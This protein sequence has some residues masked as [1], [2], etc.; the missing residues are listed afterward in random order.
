MAHLISEAKL[1]E[2]FRL[3]VPTYLIGTTY[4][5]S[6]AF[7]ESVVLP[8]VDQTRLHGCVILCDR[9]GFARAVEE[10]AALREATRTYSFTLVPHSA[11]FHPK[12]WVMVNAD[13]LAILVGSGNLTQS[14]FSE[15]FELFEVMRVRRDSAVLTLAA[16]IRRY[17][18]DLFDL[19]PSHGDYQIP[20]R[21]ILRDAAVAVGAL[22]LPQHTGSTADEAHFQ[23]SFQGPFPTQWSHRL[24]P[25]A[26]LWIASPFFGGSTAGIKLLRSVLQPQSTYVFPALHA[27]G[28]I[29]LPWDNLGDIEQTQFLEMPLHRR[30]PAFAHFKLYGFETI[31]GE[32]WVF[33]GSVNC[34]VAALSGHNVEAG[35][36][37]KVS[38]EVFERY[39]SLGKA[40]KPR[41][42]LKQEYEQLRVG[43]MN[44]WAM[45]QGLGFDLLIELQTP[46]RLPLRNVSLRLE[47]GSEWRT[48]VRSCMFAD[49]IREQVAWKDFRVAPG[50]AAVCRTVWVQATDAAGQLVAGVAFVDDAASLTSEPRQRN[51]WRGA[52]TL[53]AQ[54]G[55]PDAAELTAVFALLDQMLI[56]GVER[57]QQT[58]VSPATPGEARTPQGAAN[59]VAI[60]PPISAPGHGNASMHFGSD[61]GWFQKILGGLLRQSTASPAAPAL[62]A[63][64]AADEEQATAES[65]AL[66]KAA[67]ARW[68]HTEMQW[69]HLKN[70]FWSAV[71][72]KEAAP[73]VLPVCVAYFL[74][75]LCV[76]RSA[77][78]A[79]PQRDLPSARDLT[80]RFLSLMLGYRRQHDNYVRPRGCA[81]G[82]NIFPPL[83]VDLA[84]RLEDLPDASLLTVVLAFFVHLRFQA[85][86]G[87]TEGFPMLLWLELIAVIPS[88]ASIPNE[89]RRR[90]VATVMQRFLR[91]DEPMEPSQIDAA[92]DEVLAV[93]WSQ[94]PGY[95]R[96]EQIAVESAEENSKP[97]RVTSVDPCTRVCPRCHIQQAAFH[98]FSRL[99]PV[100]CPQCRDLLV[101]RPLYRM[102]YPDE[103]SITHSA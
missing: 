50:V 23:S 3:F 89:D 41:T 75:V 39:F 88:V 54:E 56:T 46:G 98:E 85:G 63:A 72:V 25:V 8:H 101:P 18:D 55:L 83:L 53:L 93:R 12:T 17:L 20:G 59:L 90:E 51:A 32:H 68:N 100:I 45:D 96:L 99:M 60:W 67:E 95:K 61:V 91:E 9:L 80:L 22:T 6:L 57:A 15:N 92:L 42:Q 11:S 74:V 1:S 29:D 86:I 64:D 35:V 77:K 37:R 97:A 65:V 19:L 62:H 58:E 78:L 30:R 102:F 13:E 87:K 94:H 38:K 28:T 84:G 26:S 44:F 40:M 71:L 5:A 103:A 36:L 10:A 43:R 76:L 4:T 48:A 69:E 33:T 82:S 73:R 24:G 47:T 2:F 66:G 27:G 14:G 16:G 7:F 49:S 52:L 81:Y 21:K 79:S 34:T 70:H 31:I